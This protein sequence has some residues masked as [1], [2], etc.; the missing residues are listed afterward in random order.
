MHIITTTSELAEFAAELEKG[1]YAAIDTEFMR[2][3][4]YWPK[5]CLIQ[6]AG[7]AAERRSGRTPVWTTC[8]SGTPR[9]RAWTRLAAAVLQRLAENEPG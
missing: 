5:L 9:P 1:P 4:T 7:P 8:G 6:A 2:D 3:Q